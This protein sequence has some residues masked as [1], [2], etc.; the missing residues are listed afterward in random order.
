MNEHSLLHLVKFS[1]VWIIHSTSSILST[2]PSLTQI[3]WNN[4][5]I[6]LVEVERLKKM[7]DDKKVTLVAW[8]NEVKQWVNKEVI[9]KLT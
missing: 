3:I 2:V 6:N 4:S 5:E 7:L 9:T 8:V 1:I